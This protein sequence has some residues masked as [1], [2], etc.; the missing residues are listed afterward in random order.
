MRSIS[1]SVVGICLA[2]FVG[3][4]ASFAQDAPYPPVQ[5]ILGPA[6]VKVIDPRTCRELPSVVTRLPQAG[7]RAPAESGQTKKSKKPAGFELDVEIEEQ[8]APQ[9]GSQQHGSGQQGSMS[10]DRKLD[11]LLRQTGELRRE[12]DFILKKLHGN[13][14]QKHPEWRIEIAP[15]SSKEADALLKALMKAMNEQRP[16][17]ITGKPSPPK[18]RSEIEADIERRYERILRDAEELRREILELQGQGKK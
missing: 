11:M 16:E 9:Q 4:S 10:V 13:M 6:G 8:S 7:Q 18:T 3:Q 1:W 12:M 14:A 17:R 5:V 2:W 15:E